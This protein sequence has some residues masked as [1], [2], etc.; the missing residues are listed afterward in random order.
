MALKSKSGVAVDVLSEKR[1]SPTET[2]RGFA[3][4]FILDVEGR[5]MKRFIIQLH[6]FPVS[7]LL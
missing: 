1:K 3:G 6:C 5:N 7:C 4:C 2:L